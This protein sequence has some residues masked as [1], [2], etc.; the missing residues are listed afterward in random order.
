LTGGT[1]LDTILGGAGNDT[2]VGGG[3]DQV[4]GGLGA[5]L[6][7]LSGNSSTANYTALLQ[8]GVNTSTTIQTTELTSTFDIYRGVVAGDKIDLFTSTPA[9]NLAAV[10]LA[11]TDDTINF[12]KGTYDSGAGT[13]TY[14]ANGADTAMTY[15]TTVGAGTAYETCMPC[16]KFV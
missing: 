12:A 8:S 10:N 2:I 5:D 13:F 6:I 15:D 11:G 16:I 3:A 9:V 1:G 7:T 4:T 14:A